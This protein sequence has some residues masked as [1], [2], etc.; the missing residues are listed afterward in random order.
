MKHDIATQAST[1][2]AVAR[3]HARICAV[4]HGIPPG[5]VASYGDVASI[6][7]MPG[8]ARLVGRVLRDAPAD[9][10]L[11]WHR[12]LTANGRLA[13]AQHSPS[14]VEQSERLAAEGVCVERGRVDMKRYR[15]RPDLDEM[16]WKPS[17]GW[18]NRGGD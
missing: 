9:A 3:R 8:R 11:P 15:W 18:D 17:S 13:F 4:V 2:S 6:A 14:F 12:V 16:L 1:A 7:G 5:S 10:A